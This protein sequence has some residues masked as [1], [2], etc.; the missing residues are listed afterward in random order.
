M[1]RFGIVLIAFSVT[2]GIA[3]IASAA[4]TAVKASPAEAGALSWTG[5]YL[6]GNAG[7]GLGHSDGTFANAGGFFP[8][9]YDI[10]PD[11]ITGGGF[12]G[13]NYQLERW[14]LGVE[15]DWQRT[16]ASASDDQTIA[17]T[18]Y[19]Y[20]INSEIK[21][22]GSLRIRFGYAVDRWLVFMTGGWAWGDIS[23][24]YRHTGDTSPFYSNEFIGDGWTVGTGIEYA[25]TNNWLARV[26]YR[27]SDLG[28]SS[29]TDRSTNS[30]E[31][32]NSVSINDIRL[33]LAFK[34]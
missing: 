8:V 2:T 19:Q 23:T 5:F 10:Y 27:Y 9:P 29:Y 1:R 31:K 20:T 18:S 6:G 22:L 16:S 4:D 15:G 3:S 26:E 25:I 12:V 17:G 14:V 24:D 33:G 30:S 7:Y 21:Q 32:E 34:F 13:Y 11:G 28:T